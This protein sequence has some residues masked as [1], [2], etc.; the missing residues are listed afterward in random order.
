MTVEFEQLSCRE[1]VELVTD[2]LEGMLPAAEHERVDRHLD[3]CQGC[4]VYVEQMRQTIE[5]TGR[6]TVADVSP[7]A[8]LVLL[9]A[10][11]AWHAA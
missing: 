8:E 10:F 1:L 6:L 7:A 3:T 2:Y 5:L 4:R 9:E 11:R